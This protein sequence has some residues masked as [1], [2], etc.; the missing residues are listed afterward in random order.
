MV[1]NNYTDYGLGNLVQF[2]IGFQDK[3]CYVPKGTL[4]IV[5]AKEPL[6]SGRYPVWWIRVPQGVRVPAHESMI[7]K[8]EHE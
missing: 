2:T 4:G 5:V 7:K 1:K 3:E 6:R 8:V